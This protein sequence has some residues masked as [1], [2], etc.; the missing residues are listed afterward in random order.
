MGDSRV[1]FDRQF[2][3][4]IWLM[5]ENKNHSK[6]FK[7]MKL[8]LK[9]KPN[10]RGRSKPETTTIRKFSPPEDWYRSLEERPMGS[11]PKRGAPVHRGASQSRRKVS[12]CLG[13]SVRQCLPLPHVL[14]NQLARKPDMLL[15]GEGKE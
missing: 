3:A 13:L 8:V 14:R 15:T 11:G 2:D 1:I 7:Q 4:C 12:D 10:T 6:Y 5:S 9:E